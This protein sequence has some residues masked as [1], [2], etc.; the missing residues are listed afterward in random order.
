MSIAEQG[1]LCGDLGM[2]WHVVI[3]GKDRVTDYPVPTKTDS[4]T[5]RK[6]R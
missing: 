4:H 5:Q 3:E 2:G 1:V 6:G